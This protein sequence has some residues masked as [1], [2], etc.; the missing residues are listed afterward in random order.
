MTSLAHQPSVLLLPAGELVVLLDGLHF[1][2]RQRQWT[3]YDMALKPCGSSVC[4]FLDPVLQ[5][6]HESAE[7]WREALAGIDPD[8]RQRIRAMVT[9]G[10]RGAETISQ[11]N[12]WVHQRCH[13]HM[14]TQFCGPSHNRIRIRTPARRVRDRVYDA[15]RV[16]LTTRN[17]ALLDATLEQL[18]RLA[19]S[20]PDRPRRWRGIVRQFLLEIGAFR[21]YLTHPQ[22]ELPTTTSVIESMH[23]RLRAA[24]SRVNSPSAVW[25]RAVCFVRLHPTMCCRPAV[26]QQD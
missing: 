6:A 3:L 2:F 13:F 22:L 25:R 16:A 1:R 26:F 24:T 21:A 7:S 12:G 4:F 20:L 10:F 18:R 19:L 14:L 17:P 5:P 11:E 8:V 9:D 15:I 23:S